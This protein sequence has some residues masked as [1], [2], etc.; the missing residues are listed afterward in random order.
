MKAKK[1]HFFMLVFYLFVVKNQIVKYSFPKQ[2][3][4]L[5]PD[6]VKLQENKNY[7]NS[8][9]TMVLDAELSCFTFETSGSQYA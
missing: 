3:S 5:S 1:T 8:F 4:F 7:K 2:K 9:E 6:Y